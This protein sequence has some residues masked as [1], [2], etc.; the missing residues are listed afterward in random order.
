MSSLE[1]SDKSV[2]NL[3]SG[4]FLISSGLT[5]LLAEDCSSI[6]PH[7]VEALDDVTYGQVRKLLE[8]LGVKEISSY[9]VINHHI[10]PVLQSD[11]KKVCKKLD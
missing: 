2:T 4:I 5:H 7:L 1:Q 11:K 6:D 9:D 8:L 3:I 10:L